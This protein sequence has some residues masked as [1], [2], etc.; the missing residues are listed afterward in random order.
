MPG[1]RPVT[2]LS[3]SPASPRPWEIRYLP[4]GRSGSTLPE[5]YAER[6]ATPS[7]LPVSLRTSGR[8][9][10]G[11]GLVGVDAEGHVDYVNRA[12]ERLLGW[13]SRDL[14]GKPLLAL[15][16]ARSGRALAHGS[17]LLNALH[18]GRRLRIDDAE[19]V[20]KDRSLLPVTCA[21]TPRVADG[22]V[23]G[24]ILSFRGTAEVGN[25]PAPLRPAMTVLPAPLLNRAALECRL[26]QAI[27]TANQELKPLALLVLRFEQPESHAERVIDDLAWREATARIR[28]LLRPADVVARL[29]GDRFAVLMPGM[30][31]AS[32]SRIAWAIVTALGRP[33]P[34]I[35]GGVMPVVNAGLALYPRDSGDTL[36]LNAES[37]L[38]AARQHSSGVA[39]YGSRMPEPSAVL[40]RLEA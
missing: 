29:G 13:S 19:L 10:R 14:V 26:A 40:A 12:A 39:V 17:M 36:L 30:E 25:E 22:T 21:A 8:G 32:A 15:T 16:G 9:G 1:I 35:G 3:P 33:L 18:T 37:A 23:T 6:Q 27:R 11:E 38:A 5:P 31:V 20:R 34:L 7:S 28:R 4:L 2:V 24:T